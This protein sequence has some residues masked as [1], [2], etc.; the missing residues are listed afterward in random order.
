MCM[1]ACV[2]VCV[3]CVVWVCVGV[4]VG[5]GGCG[6]GGGAYV[7]D[8][9]HLS[10]GTNIKYAEFDVPAGCGGKGGPRG[11]NILASLELTLLREGGGGAE[12][13][14]P[15]VLVVLLQEQTG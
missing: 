11:L 5:V 6:G 9:L 14:A 3:W 12:V 15:A 4:G 13:G 7:W 1:F 10:K 2:C 8:T